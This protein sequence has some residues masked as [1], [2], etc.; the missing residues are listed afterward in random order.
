MSRITFII[1]ACVIAGAVALALLLTARGERPNV[2]LISIDTLRP[3]HL[4]CYGYH[5]IATPAIDA[6]AAE[7]VLFSDAL[8]AIPLTLP[9]HTSL[10]TGLYPVSHGVRDNG[11]FALAP[12]YTTLAEVLS[13]HGYA[14]AA[15]VGAFVLDSRFGLNQGFDIYDDDLGTGKKTS[16]F[17]YRE[18]LAEDVTESAAG[19]LSTV[20]EPFFAFVHYYDP[21]TPYEPPAPFDAAYPGRPYDGEIAYT[22][23]ALADLL[24]V[25]AD[26]GVLKN[27][28]VVLVSDHGEG[29][30]EHGELAHGILLYDT[31]VR[32]T[33]LLKLPEHSAAARGISPPVRI[34][35]VVRLID[36]FPTVLDV[37]GV[38]YDAAVDGRSLL[39]LIEGK[40]L[41][42][43]VAYVETYY[44]YLA[45]RWSPLKAVRFKKWKYILAPEEELYNVEQDPKETDN[46]LAADSSLVA[47]LK[48]NLL[49]IARRQPAVKASQVNLN[50]DELRKL[51]ALGYVARS[52]VSLP[53]DVEPEGTDP[54]TMI[55]QIDLLLGPGETAFDKGD[56]ETA[57]GYFSRL[58]ELDPGNPEAHI[59]K[60][61]TLFSLGR[62]DEAE[63]E[64]LRATDIDST[65]STAF[66]QLG[67]VARAKGEPD[68]ALRYYWKALE[69]LPGTPEALANIGGIL[70]EKGL[71]DSAVAVLN[72]ALEVDPA[73]EIAL[74]NM[75]LASL[76]RGDYADARAWFQRVLASNPQNVKA[77]VNVSFAWLQEGKADSATAYMELAAQADPNDP[78]IYVNLGGL[79]RAQGM[80]DEAAKAYEA[81][82]R[83]EPDNVVALFG[84]A[85]VNAQQGRRQESIEILK[86]ILDIDP[87][88]TQARTALDR[89]TQTP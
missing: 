75:G 49:E 87:E 26:R 44:P 17:G 74:V 64:Y 83:L 57:L 88:F 65:S 22:D 25:V 72:Q 36:V 73:N 84:M 78:D 14:T 30:G 31:T 19:W 7:G 76:S 42:P 47:G 37:I 15:F 50:A 5:G 80:P 69:I 21:H 68:L 35:Q 39:P 34:D 51:M 82:V 81:A 29:L 41:P 6:I 2:L 58:V 54:K 27:T 1:V 16:A 12:E 67:N 3:D 79:Y 43:E 9:S 20:R 10:L 48:G 55:A 86:R 89:L 28:L 33:F 56:F 53:A 70:H 52:A 71:T 77:L 46:V 60:A 8:T 11:T 13:S 62:L 4:G 59:H 24:D 23:Q 38:E 32:V 40:G 18:R 66:F 45:Y 85:A 61:K 63:S